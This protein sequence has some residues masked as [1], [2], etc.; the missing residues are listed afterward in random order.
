MAAPTGIP[1]QDL[2]VIERSFTMIRDRTIFNYILKM[3]DRCD[4]AWNLTDISGEPGTSKLIYVG[5][6]NRSRV[7]FDLNTAIQSFNN[8]YLD[9][10]DRLA[11]ILYVPNYRR[12]EVAKIRKDF[13]AGIYVQPVPGPADT[14]VMSQY[15]AVNLISG[16]TGF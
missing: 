11:Q 8:N 14:C 3:L 9:E 12:P 2:R 6:I 13:H 1:E 10:V 7:D 16:G 5:D 4:K 15:D